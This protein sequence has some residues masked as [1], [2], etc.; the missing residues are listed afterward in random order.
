MI[1]ISSNTLYDIRDGY[2]RIVTTLSDENTRMYQT[3]NPYLTP[4]QWATNNTNSTISSIDTGSY[5]LDTEMLYRNLNVSLDPDAFAVIIDDC[6][7]QKE[8]TEDEL[9]AFL[10]QE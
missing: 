8:I 10:E 3:Y 9:I 5:T 1:N 7:P 2:G 6:L 4:A